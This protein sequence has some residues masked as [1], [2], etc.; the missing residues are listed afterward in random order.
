MTA[1]A[2]LSTAALAASQFDAI[3]QV[4]QM[5]NSASVIINIEVNAPGF[6]AVRVLN[7]PIPSLKGQLTS[8]QAQLQAQLASLGVT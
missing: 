4:L 5:L 7:V 3:T 8:L 2:D 6:A 1:K